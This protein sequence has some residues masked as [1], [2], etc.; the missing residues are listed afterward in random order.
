MGYIVPVI[1]PIS[2]V[3]KTSVCFNLSYVFGMAEKK[4][5]VVDMDHNA[6]IT[7]LLT[8][9][10]V[11]IQK[12]YTDIINGWIKGSSFPPADA[13]FRTKYKGVYLIPNTATS[14]FL[15]SSLIYREDC[16]TQVFH[17]EV[18]EWARTEFDITLID[19]PSSL[20]VYSL[21]AIAS[22]DRAIVPVDFSRIYSVADFVAN[23]SVID[24]SFKKIWGGC[25]M[26]KLLANKADKRRSSTTTLVDQLKAKNQE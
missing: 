26:V 13:L 23:M 15:E 16:G 25:S 11:T 1:N 6:K 24:A 8:D 17:T 12:S 4:V 3:G 7:S 9:K 14:A 20:G 10:N 21:Q 5:L 18:S 19:C 22:A 2:G